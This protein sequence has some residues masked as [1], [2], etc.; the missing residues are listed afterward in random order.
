[1][2]GITIALSSRQRPITKEKK[3]KQIEKLTQ[4]L[5]HMVPDNG[6]IKDNRKDVAAFRR[7]IRCEEKLIASK[8]KR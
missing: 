5:D 4:R 1:L 8:L 3:M 6:F 2:C 7:T